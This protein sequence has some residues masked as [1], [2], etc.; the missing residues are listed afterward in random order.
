MN[1]ELKAAIAEDKAYY[2]GCGVK[3]FFRFITHNPLYQ[4]GRYIVIA[5]K[6]GYYSLNNNSLHEK[7]FCL[8]YTRQKNVLGEKLHIELGPAT[9]GRRLR[10]Y[11]NDIVVNAGAVIGDDCELYGNNCIGNKGSQGNPLDAPIVGDHV[12]F[13]VGSNAIGKIHICSHVQ[14]SSM[15]LVNKDITEEGLYGGVPAKWLGGITR[16]YVR[17]EET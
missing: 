8:W 13:G 5:R 12:S 16:A 10:I 3:H 14:I 7:I 15:S 1:S 2:Y 17:E 6:A 9:F 4:R 11:H